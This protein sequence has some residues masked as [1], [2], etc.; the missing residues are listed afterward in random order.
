M[1]RHLTTP[2]VGRLNHDTGL[3]RK[4][5][6]RAAHERTALRVEPIF[7]VFGCAPT[8]ITKESPSR[9]DIQQIR[10]KPTSELCTRQGATA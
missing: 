10:N 3:G 7:G 6:N 4:R 8:Q 9:V 1:R 5:A 2:A